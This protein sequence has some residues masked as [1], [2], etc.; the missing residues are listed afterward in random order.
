LKRIIGYK[1]FLLSLVFSGFE[2]DILKQSL[3]SELALLFF[4]FGQD[5][6]GPFCFCVVDCAQFRSRCG[7]QFNFGFHSAFGFADGAVSFRL[8]PY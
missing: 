4:Q 1:S 6:S 5:F 8:V 7:S 2:L 3:E